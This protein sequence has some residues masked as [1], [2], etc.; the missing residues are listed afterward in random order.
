MTNT[1]NWDGEDTCYF[2]TDFEKC[3]DI[4]ICQLDVERAY[5]V[6]DLLDLIMRKLSGGGRKCA[7]AMAFY[8]LRRA[9]WLAA[10]HGQEEL[11]PKLEIAWLD[12]LYTRHFVKSVE[13]S[14]NLKLPEPRLTWV[15]KLGWC[16]L[17]LLPAGFALPALAQNLGL[18]LPG[19]TGVAFVLSVIAAIWVLQTYDPGRLPKSLAT[20]ADLV[21][22][23]AKLNVGRLV[24]MGADGR[25]AAIWQALV[26][27][28]AERSEL[29]ATEI[30]R[31]T[32]L[33]RSVFDDNYARARLRG[34]Y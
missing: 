8:R 7:S 1:L 30:T 6:G 11:T 21:E 15:G 20:I 24:R 33:L 3:F 4:D 29:P 32:V 27:F 31:D 10:W 9:L 22:E 19:G 34:S 5:R 18:T 28:L 26:A 12:R 14:F 25:E 23:C 17:L 13:Q 2:L 16:M